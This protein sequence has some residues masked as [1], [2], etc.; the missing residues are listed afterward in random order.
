MYKI[1]WG[2]GDKNFFLLSKFGLYFTFDIYDFHPYI[3]PKGKNKYLS[4]T[5]QTEKYFS[6]IKDILIKEY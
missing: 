4:G 1:K 6:S 5:F 2:R 3:V